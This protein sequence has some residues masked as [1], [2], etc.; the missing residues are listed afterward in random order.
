MKRRSEAFHFWHNI[1]VSILMGV[2]VLGFLFAYSVD[3]DLGTAEVRFS[4]EIS[5]IKEQCSG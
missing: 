3:I 2:L 5:T 1:M 4:D